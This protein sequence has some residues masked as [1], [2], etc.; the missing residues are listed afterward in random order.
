MPSFC[1]NSI[2]CSMGERGNADLA[3]PQ[4]GN[5]GRCATML[6]AL[7]SGIKNH[8][9]KIFIGL[10]A[11][12]ALAWNGVQQGQINGLQQ[13][14]FPRSPAPA[15]LTPSPW[16][17]T[18]TPSPWS[19][20]ITP[21]PVP[22]PSP[23]PAPE[24]CDLSWDGRSVDVT[25]NNEADILSGFTLSGDIAEL[26][27]TIKEADGFVTQGKELYKRKFSSLKDFTDA[28][29]TSVQLPAMSSLEPHAF[30]EVECLSKDGV[31]TFKNFTVPLNIP[32]LGE[33]NQVDSN[34]HLRYG[35]R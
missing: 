16:S 30:Y 4:D 5:D 2:C 18:I 22:S 8:P 15:P 26:S 25:N 3:Q 14:V 29:M 34:N 7:W 31:K 12:S 20:T 6:G 28:K 23:S 19:P 27:I 13:P 33:D 21:S 17:P 10:L 24:S 9:G 35:G 32:A 1:E 11:V